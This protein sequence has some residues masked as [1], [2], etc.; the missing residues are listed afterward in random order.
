[1]TLLLAPLRANLPTCNLQ[2]MYGEGRARGKEG[3]FGW[4]GL[5]YTAVPQSSC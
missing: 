4:A 5:K 1:M 3:V 2:F